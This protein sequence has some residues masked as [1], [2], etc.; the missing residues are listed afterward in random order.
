MHR[1]ETVMQMEVKLYASNLAIIPSTRTHNEWRIREK[2]VVSTSSAIC[3][4]KNR[5]RK[6]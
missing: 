1:C 3:G 6:T 4:V 2:N 5:T